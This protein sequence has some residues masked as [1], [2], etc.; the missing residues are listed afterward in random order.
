MDGAPGLLGAV[1]LGEILSFTNSTAQDGRCP[2]P[3]LAA[4]LAL[5]E[6]MIE[7]LHAERRSVAGTADF[8]LRM[9]AQHEKAATLLRASSPPAESSRSEIRAGPPVG[10]YPTLV[11]PHTGGVRE[12]LL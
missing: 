3:L 12:K 10:Q 11:S 1:P 9:I 6:E 5:N 2:K 7:Q 8:A 4:L